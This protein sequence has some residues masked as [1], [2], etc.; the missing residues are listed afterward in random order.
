VLEAEQQDEVLIVFNHNE[1]RPS[2]LF[3]MTL[4]HLVLAVCPPK[5]PRLLDLLTVL[6]SSCEALEK[7][8]PVPPC[9]ARGETTAACFQPPKQ[10]HRWRETKEPSCSGPLT[11]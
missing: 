6:R 11:F 10:L 1:G 8:L 4:R 2:E 3:T 7:A 5:T 9:S